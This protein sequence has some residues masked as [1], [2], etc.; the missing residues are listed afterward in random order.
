[1]NRILWTALLALACACDDD[2]KEDPATVPD[3]DANM[4]IEPVEPEELT[5][6]DLRLGF[7]EV[8]LARVPSQ[9]TD[10]AFLPGSEDELLILE[11]GGGVLHLRVGETETELLGD[12]QLPG[13]FKNIDCGALGLAFDPDFETNR[14][15]YFSMC[16]DSTNAG[17][18]RMTF[19]PPE[20]GVMGDSYGEVLVVTGPSSSAHTI[21]TIGFFSDGSMWVPFGDRRAE[22]SQD[23]AENTGAMLRVV[24]E[25]QAGAFGYT[26]WPNNPFPEAPDIYAYGLRSP[27]RGTTDRFDRVWLGDVGSADPAEGE[28]G[29]L[30]YEE[31]NLI[32]RPGLNLGWPLAEGPCDASADDCD[33]LTDPLFFYDRSSDNDYV[34]DDE[35]AA[36]IADRVITVG[37]VYEDRGNDPYGGLL[38]DRLLFGEFCVGFLRLVEVDES[39]EIQHDVPVGHRTQ[40]VSMAQGPD[41]YL[42][43]MGYGS[44]NS[45]RGTHETGVPAGALWRVKPTR[46]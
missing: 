2:T 11:Q 6:Q 17:V 18:F 1:M 28:A 32:D 14:Y 3:P 40:L 43:G 15:V 38:T 33:G 26:A 45:L 10:M 25:R 42:Y 46:K 8:S 16:L 13:V 5:L 29:R 24:P 41:G 34:F 39:G 44:C 35:D 21:G 7:E 19:D 31:V 37:V 36:P 4:P 20:Y 22:R 30:S 9:P 23:L 12:F 27:W